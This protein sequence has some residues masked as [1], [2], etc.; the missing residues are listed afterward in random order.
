MFF[1]VTDGTSVEL[2]IFD[3]TWEIGNEHEKMFHLPDMR[4]VEEEH[5]TH[6][7]EINLPNK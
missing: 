1:L 2:A 3:S 5:I 6:Y 7:A 4:D